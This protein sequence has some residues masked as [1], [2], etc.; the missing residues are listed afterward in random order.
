MKSLYSLALAAALCQPASAQQAP[1]PRP[2]Q[3]AVAAADD[4]AADK[5][6]LTDALAGAYLAARM[7]AMDSDFKASADYYLK[8]IASDAD[9]AYLKDSALVALLAAGEVGRAVDL[10]DDQSS[11]AP[12]SRLG[13]LVKR[14]EYAHQQDWSGLLAVLD[15]DKPDGDT[16][17]QLLDGVL[18]AWALLGEG[19]ASEA[20]AAFAT[21]G[22][23]EEARG[24]VNYHLALS[25]ALVGDYETAA[26]LLKDTAP[27]EHLMGAITEAQVLAQLDRRE[28]AVALLD[29]IDGLGADGVVEDLKARLQSG[30]PVAFDVVKDPRDGIAQVFLTFA[31]L[32]NVNVD[33][34]P[35]G[36]IHARLASYIAPDL[37]DARLMIAQMLQSIGQF[38][39][40]EVEY[41]HLRERGEMRPIGELSRIDALSRAERID[42]AIAAAEALTASDPDMSEGWMALGDLHR[43]NEDFR[44]SLPPYEKGIA[45][46]DPSD[47]D[48]MWYPLYARAISRERLGEFDGA[49][50]DLKA[51][52][53][54]RP[55]NAQM[56]NYLGYSYIDRG[57][58]LDEALR[59]IQKAAELS[60][61]DGYIMDSLGWVF[62]RLGRYEEAVA[63][64][65]SA[66]AKMATDSLVND[67]LGD[68][69]WM[70]GR[71]REAE[72]QWSRALSLKPETPEIAQRIRAKL[73]IG[74]D[75]VLAEEKANGGKLPPPEPEA[76]PK[77]EA[78][79][80]A[81]NA[82]ESADADPAPPPE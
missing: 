1:S 46:I 72:I 73:D 7:A 59:L 9:S 2:A 69:Y 42:E 47:T 79:D 68:I 53:E 66:V 15:A 80:V 50:H 54:I 32:L 51:A 8:A 12:H 75:H 23:V 30:E 35:L 76:E 48:Q 45:L 82:P 31:T 55:D 71:K 22:K 60:P 77:A 16:T 6:P 81:D 18:R 27:E 74:L 5:A 29:K 78:A 10:A 41:S 28:D 3:A 13:A 4:S 44:A 52:L 63:P 58:N 38:D 62:Y 25:K 36:L 20:D 33:S 11:A 61:D 40:A 64:Q 37:S 14:A 65:E 70:V 34:G 56:L 19:K 57:Q 43:Q 21:L 17:E 39:A 67:H 24:L 49:E 26:S